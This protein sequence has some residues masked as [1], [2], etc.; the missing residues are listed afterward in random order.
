MTDTQT[1]TTP[2]PRK[3]AWASA[4]ALLVAVLV[5]VGAVLPA[6]YGLD[7]I[8]TG[9]AFGLLALSRV[10]PIAAESDEYMTDMLELELAPGEWVE[11]TYE[12]DEGASM[13]FSWTASGDVSYNFHS[14]PDGA[15]PGYAE[16]YDAQESDRA[17]GAYIAP[18]TGVHGW[19]WENRGEEYVTIELTTAGFY[20]SAHQ[21]RPRVSGF[22]S[23]RN[24]RG[25]LLEPPDAP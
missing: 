16:S 6:E 8:G 21:A 4:A 20:S 24:A 1:T 13:L 18:F 22:R 14:A 12:L 11:S 15:P 19:Y 3:I 25:Q 23:L 7:P 17:H 9:E 2:S 5:V 10:Q